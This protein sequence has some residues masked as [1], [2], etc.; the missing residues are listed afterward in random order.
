[1]SAPTHQGLY[2]NTPLV[3]GGLLG[4][5]ALLI[6]GIAAALQIATTGDELLPLIFGTLGVFV[7]TFTICM[8][9]ALR[10]HRWTIEPD[11]VLI[12]ERPLVP[13]T[14]RRRTRRVPFAEIAALSNV[15]NAADD[16]LALVTREGERFR[17]AARPG[18]GRGADPPARSGKPLQLCRPAPIGHDSNRSHRAVHDRWPWLLESSGRL[19][20]ARRDIAAEPGTGRR[21]AVGP[22]GRRH[23]PSSRRRGSGYLGDAAGRRGLDAAPGMAAETIGDADDE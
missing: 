17:A 18:A 16:L 19:G 7:L 15:Q 11:G 1:M 12:E 4:A 3:A 23:R 2:R 20:V 22:V 6:G 13:L 9:A 21:S 14:G 5:I 10:R 8:L